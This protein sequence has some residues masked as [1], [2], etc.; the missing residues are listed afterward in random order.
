MCGM[1]G[2]ERHHRSVEIFD[3]LGLGFVSA[4][5]VNTA[6]G[7]SV[8]SVTHNIKTGTTIGSGSVVTPSAIGQAG[9]YNDLI[10]GVA[11]TDLSNYTIAYVGGTFNV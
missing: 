1:E 4:S 5:G 3:V 8:T 2:Q 10:S 6:T 11:G 7:D 9:V